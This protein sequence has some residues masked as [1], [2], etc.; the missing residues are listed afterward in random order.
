MSVRSRSDDRAIARTSAIGLRREA[1]PP[2]P[3]VMPSRSSVT[4]SSIVARLSATAVVFR[5]VLAP[6]DEGVARLVARTAEV[7]LEGETLLE[8]VGATDVDRVDAVE[9]LLGRT[10]HDRVDTRDLCRD[11]PSRSAQ[12]LA[13]NDL[14]DAAVRCQL[15]CGGSF[16]G[17]DH[18]PHPVL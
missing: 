3:M 12:L 13:G 11:L 10:H 2:M 8:P 14:Q 16:R 5:P 6:V 1:Q 15:L 17:V 18:V 7:E 4:T 9:R